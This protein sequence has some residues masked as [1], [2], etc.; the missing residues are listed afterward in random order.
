M[1]LSLTCQ[2][3]VCHALIILYKLLLLYISIC[4]MTLALKSTGLWLMGLSSN[5]RSSSGQEFEQGFHE[6]EF[7][8]GTII[9]EERK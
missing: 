8:D 2:I 1:V 5:S 9:M 6:E 7:N 3:A 4:K